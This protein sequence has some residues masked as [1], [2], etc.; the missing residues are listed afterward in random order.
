MN[1]S[2]YDEFHAPA[3]RTASMKGITMRIPQHLALGTFLAF[4]ALG[5][6]GQGY[7]NR[8]IR[9]VVPFPAGGTTD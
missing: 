3:F 5:A 7:P 4:F 2:P 1:R 6:F 8:T 9:L